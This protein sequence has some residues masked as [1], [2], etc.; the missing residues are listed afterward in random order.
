M[1]VHQRRTAD[2]LSIMQIDCE[3]MNA[4]SIPVP[5]TIQIPNFCF[6]DTCKFQIDD[7]GSIKMTTSETTLNNVIAFNESF[8]S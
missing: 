7:I 5:K 8:I 4:Y 3:G 6:G 1:E 2:T